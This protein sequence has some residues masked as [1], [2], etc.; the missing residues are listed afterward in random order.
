VAHLSKHDKATKNKS[1]TLMLGIVYGRP[2]DLDYRII[3]P[4]KKILV[5]ELI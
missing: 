3:R 2:S 4:L 1:M 5:K